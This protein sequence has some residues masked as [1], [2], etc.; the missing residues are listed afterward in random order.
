MVTDAEDA[1]EQVGESAAVR[2]FARGGLIAYGLVHLVIGW[3]ALRIAWGAPDRKGADP[4]GAITNLADQPFGKGVL[5]CLAVGLLAL[6]LWQASEAI[7]GARGEEKVGQ[8]VRKKVTSAARAVVYVGLGGSAISVALGSGASSSRSQQQATS[9]VL[10][11]PGGQV[12]VVIVGLVVVGVGVGM[13][14]R[15]VKASI[16][17]E[18]DLASMSP[19]T[20]RVMKGL[21]QVG[22][23]TKGVAFCIVGGLLVYAAVT[24]DPRKAQ[25]LDGAMQ[26]ILEQPFGAFLLTVVAIGFVAFGLY[27]VL[28]ARFHRM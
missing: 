27:S 13:V 21:G 28:Q 19:T 20:R 14:V 24:F 26:T 16:G 23:G 6:G 5:W 15:G 3:S 10:A 4:S 18:S 7:W 9:G 11:W 17:D 22:Y 8:R 12:I 1:A 25:G 2:W